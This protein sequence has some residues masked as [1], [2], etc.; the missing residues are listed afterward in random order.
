MVWATMPVF[1]VLEDVAK[2]LPMCA[3]FLTSDGLQVCGGVLRGCGRQKWGEGVELSRSSTFVIFLV[4]LNK[5]QL[6]AQRVHDREKAYTADSHPS[7]YHPS[8]SQ[9]VEMATSQPNPSTVFMGSAKDAH[10]QI[11][12]LTN[13]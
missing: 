3:M 7:I 8:R 13:K 4:V 6:I 10:S 11:E 1:Q 2:L 12:K 5:W 9:L